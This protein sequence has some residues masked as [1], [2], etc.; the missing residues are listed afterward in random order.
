[1]ELGSV[2][3]L[4]CL[5]AFNLEM[6]HSHSPCSLGA[7]FFAHSQERGLHT[8]L[9]LVVKCPEIGTWH[10]CPAGHSHRGVYDRVG[11]A[12]TGSPSPVV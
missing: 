2:I 5:P 7:W 12:V 11:W 10:P 9:P 3:R 8:N 1:M 4:A 6:E